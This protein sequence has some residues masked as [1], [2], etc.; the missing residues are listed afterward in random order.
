MD[1]FLV[2]NSDRN[3]F[4]WTGSVE[5]FESYMIQRLNVSKEDVQSKGNNGTCMVW[6]TPNVTFNF[7][8]KTKTLKV[9]GKAVDPSDPSDPEHL[10]SI[11]FVRRSVRTG[12]LA[13]STCTPTKPWTTSW[14]LI[15]IETN[16]NGLV[17]LSNLN[18]T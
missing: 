6:K 15:A 16:L 13:Y 7:Y 11:Q 14:Y 4:K 17:P 9:Q 18:L 3:Q 8:L 1:D 12:T 5:Q 10:S 2:F